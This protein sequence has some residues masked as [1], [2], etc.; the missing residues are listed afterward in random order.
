MFV[1]K[2]G[3]TLILPVEVAAEAGLEGEGGFRC[4]TL[5]V[6]SSLEAVGLTAVFSTALTKAGLSANVVAGYYHD[7][8]FVGCVDAERALATLQQLAVKE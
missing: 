6:H 5:N 3:V 2:E 4:I 1:E 8:I 7:H